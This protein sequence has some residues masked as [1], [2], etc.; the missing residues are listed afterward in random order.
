MFSTESGSVGG[1][2]GADV[3]LFSA[4]SCAYAGNDTADVRLRPRRRSHGADAAGCR[5]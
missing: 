1:G 4:R 2:G 3:P 5:G